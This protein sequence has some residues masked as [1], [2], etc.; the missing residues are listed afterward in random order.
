MNAAGK[1]QSMLILLMLLFFAVIGFGIH[2]AWSVTKFLIG[3]GLFCF[4]PIAF[5][6]VVL[7][8]LFIPLWLPILIVGLLLSVCFRRV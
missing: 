3:L 8:G 7:L 1:E 6:L 5:V 4:L 2:M